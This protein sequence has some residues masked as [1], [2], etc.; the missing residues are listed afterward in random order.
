[1]PEDYTFY[2]IAKNVESPK[3]LV[4]NFSQGLK[5]IGFDTADS[6]QKQ[7]GGLYFWA[8]REN[9]DRHIGFLTGELEGGRQGEVS[10]KVG[11][12]QFSLPS[13]KLTFPEFRLDIE[14]NEVRARFVEGFMFKHLGRMNQPEALQQLS[15]EIQLADN[16]KLIG[17]SKETRKYAENKPNSRE[18]ECLCLRVLKDGKEE[19]RRPGVADVEKASIWLA[20]HSTE[21]K[22][23]YSKFLRFV[24]KDNQ[25]CDKLGLAFKYCGKENLPV[26]KIS[27]HE[28]QENGYKN[29]VLYDREVLSRMRS[30]ENY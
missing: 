10:D 26:S 7:A 2:H 15:S 12:V 28:K 8:N 6:E 11:E 9:A 29:T 19:T 3:Q 22:D 5:P 4:D 14:R 1:M 23:T 16:E 13:R 25:Q 27:L 18:G 24:F 30:R 17:F 20:E 21:F